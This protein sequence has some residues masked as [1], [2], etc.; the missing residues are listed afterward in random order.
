ME[1]LRNIKFHL[2][3]VWLIGLALVCVT[4]LSLEAFQAENGLPA[5]DK[6]EAQQARYQQ[7]LDTINTHK[8]RL[9]RQVALM[10][11]KRVDPDLLE[12]QVRQKLGFVA[13]D[14]VVVLN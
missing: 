6:L 8:Q 4:W 2:G 9:K 14:E 13:V 12:E 5:L 7:Q 11:E 1:Q 10:D 3:R